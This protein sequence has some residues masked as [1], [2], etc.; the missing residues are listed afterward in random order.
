LSEIQQKPSLLFASKLGRLEIKPHEPKK[1]G[2]KQGGK[3]RG[4]TKDD[5][6][7]IKKE[8]RQ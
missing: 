8:K 6:N 2:T 1:K 5:K 7:Q 4:K 3:R